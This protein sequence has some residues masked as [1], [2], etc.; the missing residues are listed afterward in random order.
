M[1]ECTKCGGMKPLEQFSRNKRTR[2]GLQPHC[3]ACCNA[4]SAANKARLA[5]N[6]RTWS[7]KNKEY[8]AEYHRARYPA[9]KARKAETFRAWHAKNKAHRAETYRAWAEANPERK[10]HQNAK[11]RA[12]RL[13]R[14]P[15]WADL[16]EI[17]LIYRARDV[18]TVMLGIPMVVDHDIPL[19][20]RFVSGLHVPDNLR[21]LPYIENAR[22][23]NKF[24]LGDDS[25]G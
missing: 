19:Q 21:V 25:N 13:H 16:E 3:K 20:G 11:R 4:Y 15:P 23:Y 8:L 14:L 18:M 22:K 12:A 7:E 17:K 1:K 24:S 5:E 9:R 6:F 2:D 10:L